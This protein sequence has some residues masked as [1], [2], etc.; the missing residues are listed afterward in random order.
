MPKKEPYTG[1]PDAVLTICAKKL[2]RHRSADLMKVS[3][4]VE[5][6]DVQDA[7][8]DAPRTLTAIFCRHC[9]QSPFIEPEAPAA[10]I[11]TAAAAC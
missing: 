2:R 5:P 3:V 8:D 7:P 6:T 10:P 9:K 1:D 11:D 4:P